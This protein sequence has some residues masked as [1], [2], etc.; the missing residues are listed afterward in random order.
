MRILVAGVGDR[1]MGDDGIGPAIIEELN[2]GGLPEGVDAVDYG[3]SLMSLL[4]DLPEY[5]ALIVVDAVDLGGEPGEVRV[6]RIRPEDLAGVDKAAS[7]M[8][9][10]YHEADL[11]SVLSMARELGILPERVFLV[12]VHPD[13]VELSLDLSETARESL[14]RAVE[15]IRRLLAEIAEGE[16][17]PP[18]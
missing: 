15:L 2:K 16:D 9:L 12:G 18:E 8:T 17:F 1:L 13:R 5:D 14:P 11:D 4:H 10:S 3:T 6:L 7:L